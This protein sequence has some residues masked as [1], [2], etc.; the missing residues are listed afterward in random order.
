MLFLSGPTHVA[1]CLKERRIHTCR[2]LVVSSALCF[3]VSFVK[4]NYF[5]GQRHVFTV[6]EHAILSNQMWYGLGASCFKYS[7]GTYCANQVTVIIMN[8]FIVAEEKCFSSSFIS[9]SIS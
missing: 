4:I 2:V 1:L 8:F 3:V 5:F 7:R 6:K 9:F